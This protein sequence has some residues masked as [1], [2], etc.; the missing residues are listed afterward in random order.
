[1]NGTSLRSIYGCHPSGWIQT[2]L[3]A[4]WFLHL[5]QHVKL[6][7]EDRALLVSDGHYSRAGSVDPIKLGNENFRSFVFDTE[8][9]VS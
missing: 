9:A 6:T 4:H 1:M 3:F 5:N 8:D 7:A 2:D